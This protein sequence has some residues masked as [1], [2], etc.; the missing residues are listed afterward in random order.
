M[1]IVQTIMKRFLSC[2]LFLVFWVWFLNSYPHECSFSNHSMHFENANFSFLTDILSRISKILPNQRP[3]C[4]VFWKTCCAEGK[5]YGQWAT[6]HWLIM[7]SNK[8]NQVVAYSAG[9]TILEK[10]LSL[11]LAHDW[12]GSPIMLLWSIMILWLIVFY[13]LE[14]G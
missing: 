8:G 10:K 4:A 13:S 3:L 7:K 5:P 1:M 6:I 11:V 12:I 2:P 9:H 14:I